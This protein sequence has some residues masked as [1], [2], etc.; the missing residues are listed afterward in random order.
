MRT[1]LAM[2]LPLATACFVLGLILPL[3]TL[4]RLYFLEATPS[5]VEV[6]SGLWNDGDKV[7]AA[8]VA[9][10]SI[11]F[12]ATKILTLHVAVIGGRRSG[13]LGV[14]AALGKWSMMD[15]MLVALVIFAAKTSGLATATTLPG[16]WFYASATI[17]TA[18]A[19]GLARRL[20]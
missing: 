12:P 1:V 14:M 5:L 4:E 9:A 11:V 13:P 15:V 19:A 20:L 6:V 18:A 8:V 3:M 2:L 7:L 17:F 10:F 16:L